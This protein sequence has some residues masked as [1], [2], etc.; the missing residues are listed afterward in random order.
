MRFLILTT[1]LLL[2][3]CQTASLPST[4]PAETGTHTSTASKHAPSRYSQQLTLPGGKVILV[5][6]GDQEAVSAGSY[7]IRLYAGFEPRFPTDDFL[8]GLVRSRDGTVEK[9]LLDNNQSLNSPVIVVI[10]R[11]AGSGGYLS[12]D[13]FMVDKSGRKLH[14]VG[15]VSGLNSSDDLLKALNDNLKMSAGNL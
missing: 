12:A 2:S 1:T 9:V 7:S 8:S 13:G 6:E 3:A 10:I 15:Y 11:S 5:T 4:N 14:Q